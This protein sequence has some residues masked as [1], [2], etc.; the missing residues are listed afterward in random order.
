[1][2]YSIVETMN[3]GEMTKVTFNRYE[4]AAEYLLASLLAMQSKTRRSS[5]CYQQEL[6]TI[7]SPETF[8]MW[9]LEKE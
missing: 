3:T 9:K 1:M 8:R 5:V 6:A 4:E 2:K 7:V